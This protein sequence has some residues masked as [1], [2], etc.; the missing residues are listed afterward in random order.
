MN[1]ND[2][3]DDC[4]GSAVFDCEGTCDGSAMVDCAGECNGNTTEDACGECGGDETDPTQCIQDGYSLDISNVNPGAG[5]LDIVMNN[6]DS[7]A[8]FQFNVDGVNLTGGAGGSSADAGFAVSTS[9]AG[10]VLG[11]SFTGAVIPPSNGVLVTLTF[12]SISESVCLSDVIL[13]DSNG[14]AIAVNVGD[15][16]E[17][18]GCMDD[19]ACNYDA[20]AVVDNGSCWYVGVDNNYCDCDMNSLDIADLSATGGLNELYQDYSYHNHNNYYLHQH[21]SNFHCQ[22][23]HPHH[24]YMH[25][26]PYNQT[27]QNNLQH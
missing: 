23:Q 15:C 10:V 16:F 3:N 17:G 12:D 14:E 4:G 25:Y 18:F 26:H 24:S 27:L 1:I 19:N 2:C 5:T 11:F 7:V 9:S 22:L 20:D 13:S 6:E 8:G 21:T